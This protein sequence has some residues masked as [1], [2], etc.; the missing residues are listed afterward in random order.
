M[1]SFGSDDVVTVGGE[2]VVGDGDEPDV[3]GGGF[4]ALRRVNDAQYLVLSKRHVLHRLSPAKPAAATGAP[5]EHVLLIRL[6]VRHH[7][8]PAVRPVRR[9]RLEFAR[10]FPVHRKRPRHV[11]LRFLK[12]KKI[13]LMFLG[14]WLRGLIFYTSSFCYLGAK[15]E[16]ALVEILN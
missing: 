1:T 12:E 14:F 6:L 3:G 7:Q 10:G 8:V 5:A 15:K 11:H 13:I 9:A 4:S 16:E 2:R